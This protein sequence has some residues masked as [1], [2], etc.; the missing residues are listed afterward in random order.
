MKERNIVFLQDFL[1]WNMKQCSKS[2]CHIFCLI[3]P[4]LFK[5]VLH[6]FQIQIGMGPRYVISVTKNEAK[7]E[8]GCYRNRIAS[9]FNRSASTASCNLVNL[10]IT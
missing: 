6:I 8:A 7:N 1:S 3:V 5:E 2:Q 9:H 4:N 10:K